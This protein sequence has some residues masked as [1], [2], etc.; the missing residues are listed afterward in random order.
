MA[1]RASAC[2]RRRRS[3]AG[4]IISETSRSCPA[5]RAWYSPI[6]HATNNASATSRQTAM[7]AADVA[8]KAMAMAA[9]A[10]SRN[11]QYMR[12]APGG[13]AAVYAAAG[14]AGDG[15]RPRLAL[16]QRGHQPRQRLGQPGREQG[17]VAV[18]AHP[19]GG[20]EFVGEVAGQ[21]GRHAGVVEQHA[22]LEIEAEAAVI[23]IGAADD[24]HAVVD[25]QRLG[26]QHARA[27]FVDLDPGRQQVVV[28]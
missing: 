18:A 1:L 26:V 5:T 8:R 28:E 10:S 4:S 19:R 27:V 7:T 11:S 25:Q 20:S 22:G 24:R 16:Q 13:E 9:T 12:D 14:A 23:E 2:S 21:L 6:T 3:S 15:A 17:P